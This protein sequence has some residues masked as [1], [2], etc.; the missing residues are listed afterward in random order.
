MYDAPNPGP[1]FAAAD[2]NHQYSSTHPMAS[3]SGFSTG[4]GAVMDQSFDVYE[5]RQEYQGTGPGNTDEAVDS[6][7]RPRLTQE[8]LAE[9]ETQFALHHKPN[10]DYKKSL[11]ENM[12]VDYSKVNVSHCIVHVTPP[13]DIGHRTGF[14]TD[15]LKQ[16]MRTRPSLDLIHHS[17]TSAISYP[18]ASRP[19]TIGEPPGPN[20]LPSTPP[21][22][23]IQCRQKSSLLASNSTI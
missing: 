9:L 21:Q 16:N 15:E 4:E 6:A 3:H 10:T 1:L 23:K 22:T 7:S 19:C 11:A 12:G 18:M 8:Q 14:R 13:I 5:D 2:L 20:C 17:K